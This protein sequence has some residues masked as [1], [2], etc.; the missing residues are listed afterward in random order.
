MRSL[1][2]TSDVIGSPGGAGQLTRHELEA[3]RGVSGVTLVLQAQDVVHPAYAASEVPFL[4][5]YFA[6][7]KVSSYPGDFGH[8]HFYSGTYSMTVRWL[9]SRGTV[10]TYTTPAHNRE[11]SIEEARLIAGEHPYPHIT[12]DGLFELHNQCL[13]EADMVIAQS[14]ASA[15]YVEARGVKN[16]TVVP[17]GADPPRVVAPYPRP[18]RAG[19]LGRIGPD[20]GLAY[21]I[22]AWG[23][24]GYKDAELILAGEG[25]DKLKPMVER[26]ADR[27]DFVLAGYVESPSE[28]YNSISVYVQPSVTEGFG[29]G[30]LEAMGHGRPVIVSEGAG[31]RD[32]V[33]DGV[34]GYVVPIRDPSA[35]AERLEHLYRN[36]GLIEAMGRR[37]REKA[38]DYT[39]EKMRVKYQEVW[40]GM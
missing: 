12:D 7:N 39:W 37:G 35:I 11:R 31:A 8:A 2:C 32:V 15:N 4:H 1:Y 30:V 13:R 19:Y 14:H 9:K 18:F 17:P 25:T 5:D 20:K 24:L 38:M 36:Q 23:S 3:L 28:L 6:L 40:R 21:L 34:E 33:T 29:L 16:L 22:K 26:L 10:V 27:G